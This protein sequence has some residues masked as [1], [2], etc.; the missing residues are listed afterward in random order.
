MRT[1]IGIP[2]PEEIKKNIKFI[3]NEIE[4]NGIKTVKLENLHWTVRFLGDINEEQLKKVKKIMNSIEENSIEI[5]IGEIGTFPSS[6]YIKVVWIGVSKG[7]KEFT[8]FLKKINTKFSSIGKNSDIKP[9]IT[10]GRVK[11][12]KNKKE[13]LKKINETKNITIGKMKIDKIILFESNITESGAVYK[14]IESV[15][16]K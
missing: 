5:E 6:S 11:F 16:L 10:I 3:I 9:H 2:I 4:I 7:E 1:F 13:L 12:V 8:E 14:E 15:K